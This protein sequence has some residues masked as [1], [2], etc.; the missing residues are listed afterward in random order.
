MK[1]VPGNTHKPRAEHKAGAER[2]PKAEYPS[3]QLPAATP[4]SHKSMLFVSLAL[5]AAILIIYAPAWHYGFLSW[6][7]DL[8]VSSN[9]EVLRGLTGQSFV[10]AF[11]TQHAS[12]WHPLTWLSHM[13]DVELFGTAAGAHHVGNI[14]LHIANTLLLLWALFRMSGAW[15][16]SAVVAAL[17]AVHPM[18]VESVAW[19]AE[20]KDVL[21][22]FFW[23]LTL[24]GYIHYVRHPV[25]S[26]FLAVA[27]LLAL[28]LMSKP[29]L[30]TLPI[31][32]LL[33]DFWPLRR[34][35]LEAGQLKRWL[36]LVREKIPLFALS[37]ASSIVTLIVQSRG[38][39]VTDF[40]ATPLANR[41]ANAL[42]S[43]VAYIFQ[44]LWPA[45]LTA[46]YPYKPLSWWLAGGSLIALATATFFAVR[47]AR[48]HPYFPVGW[49]WYLVTLLPVIGLIQVGDQARAD[50]YAY[51]PL[52]GLF[53]LVV[54][55]VPLLLEKWRYRNTILPAAAMIVICALAAAARNQVGYWRSDLALWSRSLQK[56]E[57]G[58]Y[59]AHT[60]LGSALAGQGELAAA[61]EQHT[62][63]LRI[64]PRLA[65]A[66]NSLGNIYLRQGRL[67][68]AMEHY[69]EAI[70]I[71]PG[72][73]EAH[74]N[75]GTVLGLQ[76]KTK[77]AVEV[78][79]SILKINPGNPVL[80]YDLGCALVDDGKLDEAIS[81]FNEALRI[82]PQHLQARNRLGNALASQG[83]LNEAIEQYKRAL[84]VDAD[85]LEAH[86]NIGIALMQL[87]RDSEALPY[88]ME[89]LR[90]NPNMPQVHNN[91]GVILI[92]QGQK[93]RAIMHFSEALR[94]DPDRADIRENLMNAQAYQ[95]P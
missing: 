58:N 60:K 43:C 56:G 28:G 27:L 46:Y 62:Q 42:V 54:W 51:V 35:Q 9:P 29:M 91:V 30:V 64:N 23:I 24:H 65:E 55:A 73:T 57:D 49:F 26:R 84:G 21:S 68:E 16:P 34:A 52:V 39:A 78:F 33:L 69:T 71:Q 25:R 13:L 74:I 81:Q 50:R 87:D 77:E 75:H 18:H 45:D 66:H 83:K 31:V 32:L 17:F 95:V 15:R 86:I 70:R 14:L 19:I 36:L 82:D 11:T 92:N 40:E 37:A 90:I 67:S 10:W 79:R 4:D 48:K 47:F 44:M 5:I 8:Y 7:D 94:L 41:A 93:D 61:I 88:F 6:D 80:H 85:F 38:G 63:A 22:T 2:A 59:L 53:I 89:A 72:L 1:K 3:A 76:G 12:N 20:R